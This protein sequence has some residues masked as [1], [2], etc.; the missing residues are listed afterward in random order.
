[1]TATKQ[2]QILNNK[3][4][5]QLENYIFFYDNLIFKVNDTEEV[6]EIDKRFQM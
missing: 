6:E 2:I 4:S 5:F 3:S 1:M